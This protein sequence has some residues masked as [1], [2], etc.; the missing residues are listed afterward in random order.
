[1]S[2]RRAGR[3]RARRRHR[4]ARHRPRP[5]PRAP[6]ASLLDGDGGRHGDAATVE[7]E[8]RELR[9]ARVAARDEDASAAIRPA[10]RP[11]RGATS[12]VVGE[13][14]PGDTV[15]LREPAPLAF[16][17]AQLDDLARAAAACGAERPH[18]LVDLQHDELRVEEDDVDREAHERRVDR[19]RRPQRD[20]LVRRRASCVR[21]GPRMRAPPWCRQT[22]TRSQTMRPSS[23]RS[24]S[25]RTPAGH[26]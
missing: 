15:T 16:A 13:R 21:G 20:A 2:R 14:R 17:G 12:S 3:R 24:V 22:A 19:E 10:R 18:G 9:E 5:R 23:R 26:G 8:A 7:E 25:L 4:A 1:M 6:R 11:A